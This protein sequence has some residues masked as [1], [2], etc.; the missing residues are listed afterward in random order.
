MTKHAKKHPNS[1][2]HLAELFKV[3][4]GLKNHYEQNEIKM[5]TT[6]WPNL[7]MKNR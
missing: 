5:V 6:Y 1:F 3:I 4:T 2:D 7:L